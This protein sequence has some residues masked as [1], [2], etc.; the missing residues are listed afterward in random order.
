MEISELWH[1]DLLRGR[2]GKKSKDERDEMIIIGY[3]KCSY[4]FAQFL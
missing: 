2:N 1:A 4:T 3:P